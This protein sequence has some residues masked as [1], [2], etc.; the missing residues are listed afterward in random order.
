[1]YQRKFHFVFLGSF[2]ILLFEVAN[3]P[4]QY[5]KLPQTYSLTLVTNQTEASMLT[6]RDPSLKVARNGSREAVDL[7]VAPGGS[8]S[9]GV[10]MRL[11]DF[12]AHKAY[13]VDAPT[14]ACSWMT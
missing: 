8:S 7:T 3:L 11:F 1:M 10:H 2:F 12:Q 4:A 9:K 5:A 6:G 14:N 13:T